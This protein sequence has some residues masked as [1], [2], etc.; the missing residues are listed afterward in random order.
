MRRFATEF[1][2]RKIETPAVFIAHAYAWLRGMN[3]STIFNNI[4]KI[5]EEKSSITLLG[6][7]NEKFSISQLESVNNIEAIGFRHDLPDSEGR[8]WRTE[9]VLKKDL[10]SESHD[11]VR[12]RTDC[13]A[14]DNQA[15]LLLPKNPI[16][17]NLL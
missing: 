12:F 17:L 6:E 7:C 5:D 11:I 10:N 8:V 2:V 9:V 1:P 15:Q 3:N 16:L 13:I 14:V 4:N